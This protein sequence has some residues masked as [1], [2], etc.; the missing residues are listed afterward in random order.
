MLFNIMK[1]YFNLYN[2]KEQKKINKKNIPIRFRKLSILNIFVSK[3]E[4]KHTN[5]K[6]IITI[7]I[8]NRQKKYL[9]NKLNNIKIL[10]E[11]KER[12]KLIEKQNF[13]IT[14][15]IEKEKYLI[16]RDIMYNN[17]YS[18]EDKRYKDFIK[19]SLEKEI[20]TI[21]IR[22]L[23]HFNKS[24]FEDTY[25][26]K[27][28]NIIKKIYD[29]DIEFNIINLKYVHLNSDILTELIALKLRRNK[30][31]IIKVLK[32]CFKI[33][34]ISSLYKVTLTNFLKKELNRKILFFN[35]DYINIY[36]YN[37]LSLNKK[38]ESNNFVDLFLNSLKYKEIN[39]LRLEAKGRLSKRRTASK[40]IF[41]FKYKGN[42][43][44]IDSSY[45]GLSTVILRGYLK[46]N[47]QY[48]K[49]NSKTRNGS[50]GIK[51]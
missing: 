14:E 25:L 2:Y 17:I 6:V 13:K 7:Y 30:N 16:S 46:P 23:I 35:K 1:G 44:N 37:L 11:L 24:K 50:F 51:G 45:K 41:K 4:I 8:Y 33:V 38:I 39:G 42:L 15:L 49:L 43:K 40:S 21:Y 20:L 5:S 32:K 36:L 19:K 12:I 18:Y 27:L 29:K 22:Q 34:K 10:K 48:T 3:A 26:C 9:M 31:Y 47:I 28:S